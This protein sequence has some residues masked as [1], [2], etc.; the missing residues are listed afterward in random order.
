MSQSLK[1]A[2]VLLLLSIWRHFLQQNSK[3]KHYL[4]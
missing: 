4:C 3:W 2:K 1:N